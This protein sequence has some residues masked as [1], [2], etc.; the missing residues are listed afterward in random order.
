M[1]K[2]KFIEIY[3]LVFTRTPSRTAS[4]VLSTGPPRKP[5]PDF[6]VNFK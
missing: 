3:T 5:Q 1:K 2:T 6:Y 4:G